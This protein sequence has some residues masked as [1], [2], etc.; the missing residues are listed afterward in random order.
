M[1]RRERPPVT[2]RSEHWMR[3]AVNEHR[4]A[5][6]SLV[7]N[8]FGW[9]PR[10]RIEWLSPIA[11]DAYREYYDEAFI[12]QLGLTGLKVPLS[13]FWPRSG[14]RWDALAKTKSGKLIIVEAKAY[15]RVICRA[16][17]CSALSVCE[18]PGA[19]IFPARS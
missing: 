7:A 1:P 2:Q 5:L 18:P 6:D 9:D 14:P 13:E 3:K 17:G 19:F 8:V 15:I 10:D 16:M 12:E 11:S 4:D